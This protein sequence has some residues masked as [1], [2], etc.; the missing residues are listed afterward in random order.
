ME[1]NLT[2]EDLELIDKLVE[3]KLKHYN[4]IAPIEQVEVYGPLLQSDL[5][6]Q[7]EGVD[8][9]ECVVD[10]DCKYLTFGFIYPVLEIDEHGYRVEISKGVEVH[11]LKGRFK[12]STREAYLS[13]QE[14]PKE[15]VKERYEV[16]TGKNDNGFEVLVLGIESPEK[17]NEL[18]EKIKAL[19]QTL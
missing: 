1:S 4:L 5:V 18:K 9:V 6:E 12:P 17:A 14:Q 10:K 7:V 2:K 13:Q 8:Y 11:R 16:F 15:E 19:L 3:D